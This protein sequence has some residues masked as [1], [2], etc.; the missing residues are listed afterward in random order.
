MRLSIRQRMKGAA[1]SKR[2]VGTLAI[3]LAGVLL[4]VCAGA[5]TAGDQ[6]A[7]QIA[8]YF[9]PH[10]GCTDALAGNSMP[11]RSPF[12]SKPMSSRW[13]PSRKPSWT[14]I[15]RGDDHQSA[16]APLDALR[17]PIPAGDDSV[18]SAHVPEL[19]DLASCAPSAFNSAWARWSGKPLTCTEPPA[20]LNSRLSAMNSM[21]VSALP[22]SSH[23]R[24][25]P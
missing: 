15:D 18:R 24:N 17:L 1:M 11:R 16:P 21:L 4:T 10:G 23:V 9:S 22:G 5:P 7:P 8:V 19:A 6:A 14:A 3:L 20:R 13:R 12:S 2:R 25:A